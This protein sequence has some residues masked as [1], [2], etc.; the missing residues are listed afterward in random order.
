MK[1][2]ADTDYCSNVFELNV[3][4]TPPPLVYSDSSS[5]FLLKSPVPALFSLSYVFTMVPNTS[6]E[7]A[8]VQ[9]HHVEKW[10]HLNSVTKKQNREML[11]DYFSLWTEAEVSP[12]LSLAKISKTPPRHFSGLFEQRRPRYRSSHLSLGKSSCLRIASVR[13]EMG[14]AVKTPLNWF[15]S[16]QK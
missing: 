12:V 11:W 1:K 16:H 14:L 8:D 13:P 9:W 4:Y 15:G 2:I 10:F 6:C 5:L 7:W 3:R